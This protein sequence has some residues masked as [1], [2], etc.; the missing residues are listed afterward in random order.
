MRRAK[1]TIIGAG[2]VGA[3]AAHWVAS[4]DLGDVVLVDVVQGVPQGKCLDL[5]ET[6]PLEDIDVTL[7]GTNDYAETANS[8]VIIVTAGLARKPGMSRDDLLLRN[9][10]VVSEVVRSSTQHSPDAFVIVVT[11]PLDAMCHVA[12]KASGF[13]SH[14]VVGMAGLLDSSRFRAFIGME[15]KVSV[16]D[17]VAFVMGGHGDQMVPL[18]RLSSVGGIPLTTLLAPERIEALVQRTRMAGGEI[19]ALL[20]TGSAYYSPSA[21]AVRMAAAYINDRRRVIPCSALLS[22][23]YGIDGLYIGVPI[24]LGGKGVEQ[25]FEIE[26]NQDELAAM[27]RSADAVGELVEVLNKHGY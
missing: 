1:I 2:N 6:A 17:I 24:L 20:K 8:D 25:I 22:G 10:E 27:Q 4:K 9:A 15:L 11:N 7:V 12:L 13:P 16:E 26:L 18:P 21:S 14:R 23:Q 19:V 5:T 3:T